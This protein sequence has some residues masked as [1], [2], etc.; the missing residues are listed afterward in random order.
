MS[1]HV[2]T[3]LH[4]VSA[5][6]QTR[7]IIHMMKFYN[8]SFV[9]ALKK[10]GMAI[11]QP[12]MT[13]QYVAMLSSLGISGKTELEL[14]KY[15]QQ[16]LGKG[17]VPTR[18]DVW[19]L[20]EGHGSIK[21]HSKLWQYEEG[22]RAEKVHWSEKDMN[23]EIEILLSQE[24]RANDVKPLDVEAIRAMIGGDFGATAFQFLVEV[25]AILKNSSGLSFRV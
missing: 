10:R 8:D 21:A 18:K 23:T 12:M 22:K 19:M 6:L 3:T 4:A 11:A 14:A 20:A 2:R 5:Q 17:F 25:T 13:T 16:Y 9:E 7:V 15:L 1:G 24:L